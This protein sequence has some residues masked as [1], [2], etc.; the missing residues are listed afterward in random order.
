MSVPPE[1]ICAGELLVDLISTEYAK[2]FAA[3]DTYRRLAGG[4]PANLAMNLAHLGRRVGL[5]ATVGQDDAGRLL[6]S[7]VAEAG[8][9]TTY[10]RRDERPT[11]LILVTKSRATSN[12][13]PYRSADGEILPVQFPAEWLEATRLF[14]TTAFALSRE[15]AR[16][17][18]LAAAGRVVAA[19]GLLSIDANYAD[20]I[21]PDREAA[22]EVIG[23]YLGWGALAKFSDVD[24]ERLFGEPV[25]DPERAAQRIR[26]LGARMVCLTLGERGCYVLADDGGFPLPSL[27]V[28]VKDTTGAG[29]A[30]WS[31][32][33]AA[34]L[35]GNEWKG[36]ARAGRGMAGRKL[37]VVG[38]YRA[39]VTVEEL[40][41]E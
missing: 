22:R 24:Y 9:D 1:V 4:S 21:W 17:S 2:D 23:E 12:F 16:S 37:G 5:V 31:G 33:L 11:T 14:H 28:A 32:F 8:V 15:P 30:F 27:P 29:D 34:Y 25:D 6:V 36:C 35:S 40:M 7:E 26:D 13:E 39:A 20:K 41:G 10:I 38:R 3:A 19:G 18:I